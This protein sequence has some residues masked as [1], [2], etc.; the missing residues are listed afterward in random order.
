VKHSTTANS[1]TISINQRMADLDQGKHNA[2]ES[3]TR[4]S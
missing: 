4:A 1:V 3:W 2:S